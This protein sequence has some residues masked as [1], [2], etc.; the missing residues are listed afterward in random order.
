MNDKIELDFE[1]ADRIAVLVLKNYRKYL[2]KSLDDFKNGGYLH[3]EDV[4]ES[5]KAIE[6]LNLIIKH[7]DGDAYPNE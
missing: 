2:Q 1:T 7:F 5:I 3:P 4:A 6:A